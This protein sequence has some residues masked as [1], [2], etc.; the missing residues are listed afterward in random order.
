MTTVGSLIVDKTG[1]IKESDVS[2]LFGSKSTFARV[3]STSSHTAKWLASVLAAGLDLALASRAEETVRHLAVFQRI[4]DQEWS[5]RS[6]C[7]ILLI[8]FS[9]FVGLQSSGQKQWDRKNFRHWLS[10]H[11]GESMLA[12]LLENF[13]YLCTG[14]D[15][16]RIWAR[17]AL[18]DDP[19]KWLPTIIVRRK[20]DRTC[21][22]LCISNKS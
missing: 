21:R 5:Q 3:M 19:S 11:L 2:A 1:Y 4:S 14:N 18:Q 7:L 17:N 12:F 9:N 16:P 6:T 15:P 20:P 22:H 13:I 10:L 8:D